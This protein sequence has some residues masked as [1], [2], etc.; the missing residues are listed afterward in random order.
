[1]LALVVVVVVELAG[2]VSYAYGINYQII[3]ES[4]Q[5]TPLLILIESITTYHQ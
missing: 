1:L 5:K 3:W 2:P 4:L